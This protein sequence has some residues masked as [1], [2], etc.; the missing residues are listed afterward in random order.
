M[1]INGFATKS[2]VLNYVFECIS[3]ASQKGPTVNVTQTDQ[4]FPDLSKLTN[5]SGHKHI[6][7]KQTPKSPSMGFYVQLETLAIA[8]Y[9]RK[10]RSMVSETNPAVTTIDQNQQSFIFVLSLQCQVSRDPPELFVIKTFPQ[11]GVSHL[12]LNT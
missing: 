2:K 10:S 8:A 12:S 9:P 5:S 3:K 7:Q 6:A 1:K 11:T 4:H